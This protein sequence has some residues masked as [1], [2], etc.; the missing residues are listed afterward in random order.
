[1]LSML[2]RVRLPIRVRAS[3]ATLRAR[4]G[5]TGHWATYLVNSGGCCAG[6]RANRGLFD[7][8]AALGAC[9]GS[10]GHWAKDQAS[11]TPRIEMD[12]DGMMMIMVL[13][14]VL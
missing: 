2:F 4:L 11:V 10:A 5:S 7:H 12:P 8:K 3:G 6:V 1:M 9:L 14:L 13:V